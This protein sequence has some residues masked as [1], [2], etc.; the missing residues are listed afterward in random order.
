ML[1]RCCTAAMLILSAALLL[2]GCAANKE[3]GESTNK[4]ESSS[5]SSSESRESSHEEISAAVTSLSSPAG[6]DKWFT[7]SKYST[8]EKGY[9]DIPVRVV[10]VTRGSAAKKLVRE[11]I[12]KNSSYTYREPE[13]GYEWV[14]LGYELS[15]DD[16]PLDEGGADASV[17]AFL[18][19]SDGGYIEQSDGSLYSDAVMDFYE[20]KYYFEGIV[21][22]KLAFIL[23]VGMKD[24]MVSFGEYGE[25]TG[26]FSE[27]A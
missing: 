2:S 10:K 7:A 17:T 6:T 16:F 4:H 3:E 19:G 22:G 13:K 5:E 25:T 1:R 12:E 26:Y 27:K 18:T 8:S 20:D 11:N 23:P 21:S 14:V 9:A 24:Y 15:L